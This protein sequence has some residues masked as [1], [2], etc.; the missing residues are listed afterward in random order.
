MVKMFEEETIR[1]V[2]RKKEIK[3]EK[4]GVSWREKS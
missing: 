3:K 1:K 2:E 4:S